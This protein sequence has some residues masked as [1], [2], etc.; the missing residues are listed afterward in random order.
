MVI[1]FHIARFV[2]VL[3]ALA[4]S[5]G[6][7]QEPPTPTKKNYAVLVAG[8]QGWGN[9]RHQADICH[10]F[11]ILNSIGGIPA[12]QITVMMQ[13]DIAN[14]PANPFPG[15]IINIPGGPNVYPGVNKDYTG[16]QVTAK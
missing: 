10:A 11:H 13:D 16:D 14:N 6:L 8:S 2:A 1:P 5:A 9:Y 12:N 4:P 3:L 7:A 15:N